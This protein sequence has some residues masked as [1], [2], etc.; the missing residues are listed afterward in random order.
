M[1]FLTRVTAAALAA[2][3]VHTFAGDNVRMVGLVFDRGHDTAEIA[4]ELSG[5]ESVM[6]RFR[7]KVGQ[8]IHVSLRP[9]NQHTE[10][11]L[12]APGKW[13]GE[14]MH[15]SKASGSREFKG[16]VEKDGFHAILVSREQGAS[17][18]GDTGGPRPVR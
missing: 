15:D 8:F 9:N 1:R 11:K 18:E 12:Y 7:P 5:D 16:R 6:Y 4:D 10:F 2:F 14:E 3:A 13:P 17:G